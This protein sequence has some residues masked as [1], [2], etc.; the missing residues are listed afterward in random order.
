ML[1]KDRKN[2]KGAGVLL[3]IKDYLKL[4][5]LDLQGNNDKTE[6]VL[7]HLRGAN[8]KSINIGVM[9]RPP[10]QKAGVDDTMK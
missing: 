2:K 4:T 10:D 9:Y 1:N 6:T 8:N 7:A 3:Y 5:C